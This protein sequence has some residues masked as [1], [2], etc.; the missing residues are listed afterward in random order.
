VGTRAVSWIMAY[1]FYADRCDARFLQRLAESLT[2]HMVFV[3]EHLSTGPFA[4]NHLIGDAAAL[5][6]GGLFL[7][8]R[9]SARWLEKGLSHLEEQMQRQ[10]APDGVHAERSVAYHRFVLDQYYL[11]SALLSA[12]QRS[13]SA[14]TLRGMERMTDFLMD[15][16]ATDGRAPSFGDG[17]DARGIWFRADGPADFRSALALGA[18]LFGRGD[19]KMIAG[20]VTEEVLWLLGT[21]GVERFRQLTSRLPDHTSM[22]YEHGGYYVMRSGWEAADSTLAFDC[23]PLGHGPAGHGHADALSFQ[24]HAAG[25]PFLVDPGAF[26]YNLD[27]E[28]RDAFRSTKAHNTIVV[29]GM[30]Q[31]VPADRMSWRTMAGAHTHRWLSTPWFDLVD[32]EHDGYRRLPDPV[33]HRRVVAYFKPDVWVIQ[34]HLSAKGPHDFELLMHLRPDCAVDR[35][36]GGPA[37]VLESP[38]GARLHIWT[39]DDRGTVQLPDVLVGTEQQRAAWFSPGYGTRVPSRALSF[40]QHFTNDC[41]VTTCV[42]MSLHVKPTLLD[43]GG[44][45]AMSIRRNGEGED[46]EETLLYRIDGQRQLGVPGLRSDGD[47]LYRRDVAGERTRIWA[48]NFHE[49]SVPGILEARSDALIGSLVLEEERCDVVLTAER[50]NRLEVA[51]RPGVQLRVNGRSTAPHGIM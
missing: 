27:Y 23:G 28:W 44:V 11:T 34:D 29:D 45:L 31:S 6:A 24:L 18:V 42:T 30:D 25:Y 46:A 49:L 13:L 26:S 14:A 15:V 48:A 32:G 17:D 37:V 5:V 40:R 3:E 8:H 22:S 1:P 47:L 16:V 7:D 33:T 36:P 21:E 12:N 38:R 20:G 39:L 9:H 2:R 50:D 43:E 4:N 19:F 35:T 10:V 51:V 41:T